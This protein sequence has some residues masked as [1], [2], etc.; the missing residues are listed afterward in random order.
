MTNPLLA[1]AGLPAFDQIKPE[2]VVPAIQQLLA[3]LERRLPDVEKGLRP[4]WDS[5]DALN[6]LVEP[7]ARAWGVVGHLMGVKNSPELRTAHETVQPA[8]VQTFMKVAQSEAAY[9]AARGL[10]DSPAYAALTDA[11]KRTV[12]WRIKDAEL[13]GIALQGEQRDRFNAIETELSELSTKFS[14]KV[15]DASKAWALVLT[16]KDDVAGLPHSALQMA[17]QMARMAGSADA[18]PEN[19]PWRITLDVPVMQPFLRHALRR[20][21]REQVYR[22]Y[23]TRASEL[24]PVDDPAALDN[25]ATME[26]I[27]TLRQEKAEL[28]GYQTYAELSLATKMAPG[29]AAVEKLLEELRAVAHPWAKTELDELR[30]LAK[31]GVPGV[32]TDG[33]VKHW[34]LEML[35]EKLRE[36]RFRFTDEE[37]RPYFPLPRVLDGL[38][39]L[40]E[41]LFGVVVKA[42]DGETPVWHE[43]A[44][45]FRISSSDGAPIAAFF[46]DPYSRPADKRGGAWMDECETR[47]RKDGKVR[48]PVAYLCCNQSPP[49]DGKPSLMTFREVETLFHEFGHGL[50]HMLTSVDVVDVSGIKGIEWDAVELA[51]QFMENWCYHRPT[52]MGMSRHVDTGA[53]LPDELF[54]KLKAAR[55]FRAASMMLRQVS[56]ALLD[57][58]LHHRFRPGQG[59]TVFDVQRALAATTSVMPPLPEDR[60]L[61]AFTHIFAGGYAAGYYSYKW[62][63]VLSADAFSAFE[64]AGLDDEKAVAATGRRYRDTILGL[65]GSLPPMEVFK[66]FRGREPSTRPLLQHAGLLTTEQ[67]GVGA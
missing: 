21:L 23:V 38:F 67:A 14:N 32:P 58:E 7:L 44:R 18:T 37:L 53:P 40:A 54:E 20:D 10:K 29:V 49:V 56:F 60:F 12:D 30:A 52:L 46:L 2:H 3:D 6:D 16:N 59:E 13:S 19:G 24:F 42:A 27:L 50:Q 43:D 25:R 22:A 11:Q 9:K 28:L 55:T 33:D 31:E 34:D 5:V 26:R 61:C 48:L 35:S 15:L 45:F 57:L 1:P 62:A 8:V 41:R 4:D 64:E 63:E 51:S 36:R 65:G 47:R 17:A 39:A 66:R